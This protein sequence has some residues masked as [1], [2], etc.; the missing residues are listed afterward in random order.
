MSD[1]GRYL[2]ARV[3]PPSALTSEVTN[4]SLPMSSPSVQPQER[5]T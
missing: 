5:I 2:Y 1:D 4:V 3:A